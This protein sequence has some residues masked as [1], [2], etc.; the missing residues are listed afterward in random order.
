M[1]PDGAASPRG[2]RLLEG[3]KLALNQIDGLLA[4]VAA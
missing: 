2:A 4:G 1:A 3:S